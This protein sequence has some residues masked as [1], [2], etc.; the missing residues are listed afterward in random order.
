MRN[1]KDKALNVDL[2]ERMLKLTQIHNVTFNWIK[3]HNGHP[4]N[5]R[6][7]C[8]AVA[9]ASRSDLPVDVR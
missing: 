7:D 6:C 3:G 4:E 9:A 8:L 2:W 1:N 5:E